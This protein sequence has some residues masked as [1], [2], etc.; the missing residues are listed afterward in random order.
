M[1]LC[2]FI[3]CVDTG[4]FGFLLWLLQLGVVG[5]Q[6]LSFISTLISCCSVELVIQFPATRCLKCFNSISFSNLTVL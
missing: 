3:L 6:L 2:M 1:S 5:D 4:C